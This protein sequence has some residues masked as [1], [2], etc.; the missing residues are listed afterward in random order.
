MSLTPA[1]PGGRQARVSRAIAQ[2]LAEWRQARPPGRASPAANWPAYQPALAGRRDGRY[3][4]EV[5]APAAPL[6]GPGEPGRLAALPRS[7]FLK[8]RTSDINAPQM[9]RVGFNTRLLLAF[10]RLLIWVITLIRYLNITTFDRMLGRATPQRR[11]GHLRHA[12]ERVGGTGVKVGK[13]LAMRLD[14]FPWAVCVEL[15]QM[16]DKLPPFPAEQAIAAVERRTGRPLTETFARFDPTPVVSDSV[17]GVYQGVLRDGRRVVVRVRR[18]GVGELFMA[19]L[20]VLDWFLLAAE[21]LTIL[22]PGFS[23]QMRREFRAAVLGALDFVQEARFQDSFRRAAKRSGRR[24]FTAPRV[25]FEYSNDEV[26]VQEFSAGMWMWELLAAQEQQDERVLALARD[27]NID[28]AQVARRL[29]WISYWGWDANFFFLADP[30][31]DNIIVGRD[32]VLTFLDFSSVGVIDPDKRAA[33]HQNMAAMQRSDPLGMARATITLLEPLPPVDVLELTKELEAV[34]WQALY[35]HAS[36]APQQSWRQRY[37]A[38]QWV[39][40]FRV[41]AQYGISMQFEALRLLRAMLLYESLA[42]RLCRD[43]DMLREYRGFARYRARAA[44]LRVTRAVRRTV[45]QG[46]DQKTFLRLERV[47]NMTSGLLARLRHVLSIPQA[48]FTAL[49]GKGSYAIFTLIKFN[50]QAAVVTALAL[51]ISG[52][53]QWLTTGAAPTAPAVVQ[54]VLANPLYPL[55][56]LLLFLIN[57]RTVLFH[58]DDVEVR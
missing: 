4:R 22:R 2:S 36:R 42:T 37:P 44:R 47:A 5:A 1:A 19:D 29:M 6:P 26:I 33:M 17:A 45:R 9:R 41:A 10:R 54:A 55:L 20:L 48:N 58:L 34:N 40:L 31:P 23:A 28:P 11:A 56:L 46:F 57:T 35:I 30:H 50:A 24:F 32:G 38:V 18:P 13:Y 25:V 27:L 51:L 7:R 14:F 49:I 15:A 43:L 8:V 52:G 3:A 21:F 39:G 12:F 16:V 53:L